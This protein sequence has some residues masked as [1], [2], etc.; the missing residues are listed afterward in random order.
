MAIKTR[1]P[2][3]MHVSDPH[4]APWRE[5]AMKRGYQKLCAL[6]IL[7]GEEVR[8]VITIYSDDANA[9]TSEIFDIFEVFARQCAMV[10]VNA[11]LYEE[12]R[13]SIHELWAANEK[14]KGK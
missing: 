5:E 2:Q 9:F 7:H 4:F 1:K 3:V 6:P 12:A 13:N 11:A 10:L 14:L 8:G